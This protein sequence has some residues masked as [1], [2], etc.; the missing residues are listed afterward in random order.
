MELLGRTV[1][2]VIIH[3]FCYLLASARF[4]VALKVSMDSLFLFLNEW[5]DSVS[6][7]FVGRNGEQH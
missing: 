1:S 3:G 2:R 4:L 7:P 6:S 5:T